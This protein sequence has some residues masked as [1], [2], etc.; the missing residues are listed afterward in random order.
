[1]DT[2]TQIT[3]DIQ[4]FDQKSQSKKGEVLDISFSQE[5]LICDILYV[6][7]LNGGL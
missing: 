7:D 2:L 5:D 3:S 4:L 6:Y 1:M